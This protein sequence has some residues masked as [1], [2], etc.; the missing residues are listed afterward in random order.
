MKPIICVRSVYNVE[1]ITLT[2]KGVSIPN[3][4]SNFL[5]VAG[6]FNARIAAEQW[7]IMLREQS[8]IYFYAQGSLRLNSIIEN[9]TMMF[10]IMALYNGE[11]YME[12]REKLIAVTGVHFDLLILI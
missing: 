4:T 9:S 10:Y 7:I 11:C 5:K 8:S 12:K 6:D 3:Q 2:N 1:E